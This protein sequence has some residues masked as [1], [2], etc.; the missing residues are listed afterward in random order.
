MSFARRY[1]ALLYGD[2][3]DA[4]AA[5]ADHDN[6]LAGSQGSLFIRMANANTFFLTKGHCWRS[7]VLQLKWPCISPTDPLNPVRRHFNNVSSPSFPRRADPRRYSSAQHAVQLLSCCSAAL[8]PHM[9]QGW[10]Q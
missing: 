2:M 10:P 4:V 5:S 8:L 9:L 1:N 3:G 6:L 7:A